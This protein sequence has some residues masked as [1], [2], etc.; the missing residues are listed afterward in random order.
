MLKF[1]FFQNIHLSYLRTVPP[2]SHQADVFIE[3]LKY[4]KFKKI[5][6]IHSSD[7]NGRSFLGRFQSTLQSMQDEVEETIEVSVGSFFVGFL[8][9]EKKTLL[10]K[11]LGK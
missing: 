7:P 9:E 3:I 8:I 5:I 4:F 1:D 2:F 6:L 11:I 10:L